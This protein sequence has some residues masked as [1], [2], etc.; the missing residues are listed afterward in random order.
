MFAEDWQSV[1]CEQGV[2]KIVPIAQAIWAA[3]QKISRVAVTS[4]EAF[5]GSLT[6]GTHRREAEVRRLFAVLWALWLHNNKVIFKG[7]V[8]VAHDM[9]DFLSWWFRRA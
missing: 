8:G 6:R 7:K 1:L 2:S 9:Q 5:W 3:S 4:A